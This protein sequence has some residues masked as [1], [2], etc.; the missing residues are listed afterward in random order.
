MLDIL[1]SLAADLNLPFA[2]GTD[3]QFNVLADDHR[4]GPI[5]FHNG[6]LESDVSVTNQGG[7]RRV[8]QLTLLILVPSRL[9]DL[10]THKR[11]NRDWLIELANIIIQRLNSLTTA[12]FSMRQSMFLNFTDRNL[13]GIKLTGSLTITELPVC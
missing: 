7:F 10:P 3:A 9:A 2:Y 6:Y 5:L 1:E 4:E 12:P 8:H 13:D 11:S